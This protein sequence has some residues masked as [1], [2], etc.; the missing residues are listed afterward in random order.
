MAYVFLSC[1]CL[2]LNLKRPHGFAKYMMEAGCSNSKLESGWATVAASA[3]RDI[4]AV[5]LLDVKVCASM[6]ALTM[7]V[8]ILCADAAEIVLFALQHITVKEYEERLA[9]KHAA[10]KR[11][12]LAAVDAAL[13]GTKQVWAPGTAFCEPLCKSPRWKGEL[14][15]ESGIAFVRA[16]KRQAGGL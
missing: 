16:P 11:V 10:D 3:C 8:L 5:V 7:F 1:D 6:G 12:T 9:K 2:L 13:W 4:I 14:V 15:P